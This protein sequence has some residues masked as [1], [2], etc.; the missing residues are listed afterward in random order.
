MEMFILNLIEFYQ[1][2]WLTVLVLFFA[3]I[4]RMELLFDIATFQV[5]ILHTS[6]YI[7]VR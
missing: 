5:Y 6:G 1:V 3:G 7:Q 4:T 2:L